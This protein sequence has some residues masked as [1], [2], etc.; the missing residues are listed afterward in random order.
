MSATATRGFAATA[1]LWELESDWIRLPARVWEPGF[2]DVA[3]GSPVTFDLTATEQLAAAAIPG[4]LAHV[5]RGTVRLLLD[6][7][8]QPYALLKRLFHRQL[9]FLDGEWEIQ[10]R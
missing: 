5:R 9:R 3:D 8:S 7:A 10:C 2:F 4:L 1:A 6:P